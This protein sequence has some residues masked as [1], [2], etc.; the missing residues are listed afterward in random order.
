[1]TDTPRR[2]IKQTSGYRPP[3]DIE[4]EMNA[5]VDSGEFAS[6]SDIHTASLR[7]WFE[8]RHFNVKAACREYLESEEGQKMLL[9][10]V[11]KARRK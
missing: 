3:H 9:D 8:Y 6:K 10:L 7:H 4:K 1:M 2:R 5:L 11:K